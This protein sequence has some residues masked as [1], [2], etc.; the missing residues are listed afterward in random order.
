MAC[1]SW[2]TFHLS[3]LFPGR[4]MGP[5]QPCPQG[6][7]PCRRLWSES[8]R[9][10]GRGPPLRKIMASRPRKSA[11]RPV[12]SSPPRGGQSQERGPDL[13][14]SAIPSGNFG[15]IP[16]LLAH[17]G[18]VSPTYKGAGEGT[19][20]LVWAT[21]P[22]IFDAARIQVEHMLDRGERVRT[23]SPLKEA[24]SRAVI[25][26]CDWSVRLGVGGRD[27]HPQPL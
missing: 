23:G 9:R 20:G 8:E 25:F 24:E 26:A 27:P 3:S 1:P 10:A 13:A 4:R 12:Y 2:P 18:L 22:S 17:S 5:K 14:I 11:V 19:A 6:A 21:P 16:T 7:S 15:S